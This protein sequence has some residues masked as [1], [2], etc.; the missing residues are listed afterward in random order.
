MSR[1]IQ[2]RNFEEFAKLTMQDSNQFHAVCLDTYPPIFYMNDTS[3]QIVAVVH[4]LNDLMGKTVAAYTFDAG[5]NAVI[6]LLEEHL[7]LVYHVLARLFLNSDSSKESTH[8]PMELLAAASPCST[9]Q[10]EGLLSQLIPQLPTG[11]SD[12][13]GMLSQILVTKIGSG[14]MRIK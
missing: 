14:P 8:D 5:P 13:L 6:Y 10:L 12:G 11:T 1:A 7:A 2:N 3:K 9:P 4:C